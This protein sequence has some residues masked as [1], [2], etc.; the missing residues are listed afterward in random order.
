MNAQIEQLRIEEEIERKKQEEMK[1]E[2]EAIQL[3]E[4]NARKEKEAEERAKKE[5]EELAKRK[6]DLANIPPPMP[7]V[8]EE[9]EY[10]VVE[11]GETKLH[12]AASVRGENLIELIK[13][14][15][16]NLAARNSQYHN[17][18][19]IAEKAEIPENVKQLG[20]KKKLFK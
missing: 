9:D 20:I 8:K 5:A 15:N 11:F 4:E 1:R 6:Q 19:D 14:E 2:L 7:A 17:A 18:R 12:Q 10:L 13:A 16:I 3:A